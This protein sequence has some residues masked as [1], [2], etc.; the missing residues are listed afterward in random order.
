[1]GPGDKFPVGIAEAKSTSE[2]HLID[3][4][5]ASIP[6][7]NLLSI[8][9][10]SKPVPVLILL[11]IRLLDNPGFETEIAA[12]QLSGTEVNLLG[13]IVKFWLQA[14]SDCSITC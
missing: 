13:N 11:K 9:A 5:A 10:N 14:E 2:Q 8:S 1:L 6:E 12:V 7:S 4:S 3:S